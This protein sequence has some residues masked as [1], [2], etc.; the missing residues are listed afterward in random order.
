M[1][2]A[3]LL[4]ASRAAHGTYRELVDKLRRV[5]ARAHLLEAARLR[6]EADAA[7][8]EHTDPAWNEPD[9]FAG[10]HDA[11]TEFYAAQR[12]KDR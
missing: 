10:K 9:R 4:S 8:P 1:T 7:D 11:L 6:E 2:I 5:E 12:A 3:E